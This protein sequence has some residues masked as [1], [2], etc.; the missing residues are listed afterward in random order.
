MGPMTYH[1]SIPRTNPQSVLDGL[2]DEQRKIVVYELALAHGK[3][4]G[5]QFHYDDF[6][7]NSRYFLTV[8]GCF[9]M[10]AVLLGNEHLFDRVY[11]DVVLFGN[12]YNHPAAHIG[13]ELMACWVR[14]YLHVEDG[15]PNWLLQMDFKE[16]PHEWRRQAAFVVAHTFLARRDFEKAYATARM[17]LS[18]F[19]G[20]PNFSS[21]GIRLRL[22]AAIACRELNRFDEM[23][24]LYQEVAELVE[25]NGFVNQLIGYT[26]GPS[27]PLERALKDNPEFLDRLRAFSEKHD[28]NL[29]HIHNHFT[30]NHRATNLT[31]REFFMAR[32]LKMGKSYKEIARYLEVSPGRLHNLVVQLYEK[33]N[34][35]SREEIAPYVW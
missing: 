1:L 4:G 14:Q 13:A 30:G 8:A 17:L 22:V 15:Y 31:V 3:T 19:D 9:L 18:L 5:F 2:P 32:Q 34:I 21:G 27:S 23:D 33:L 24:Q 6:S 26:I 12:T 11:T 29:V 20:G 16:V 35:H 25:P 7:K 10:G 28:R